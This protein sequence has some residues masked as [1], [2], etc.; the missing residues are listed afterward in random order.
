MKFSTLVVS[1]TLA[2][3]L[4][5]AIIASLQVPMDFTDHT[6]LVGGDLHKP[7]KLG[8]QA[9]FLMRVMQHGNVRQLRSHVIVVQLVRFY[10]FSIKE[11][12][13]Q[14]S[15]LM[16]ANIVDPKGEETTV[17]IRWRFNLNTP[18]QTN[19]YINYL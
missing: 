16:I 11:A 10:P 14:I 5:T 2:A 19:G 13:P 12:N 7:A 1:P 6:A 8:V 15:C 18:E 4:R 17:S 9:P 3:E